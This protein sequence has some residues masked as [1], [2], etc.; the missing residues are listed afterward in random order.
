MEYVALADVDGDG[1]ADIIVSSLQ[2]C[3]VCFLETATAHSRQLQSR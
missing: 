2:G 3:L 1:Y